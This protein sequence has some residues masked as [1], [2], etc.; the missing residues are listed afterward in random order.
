MGPGTTWQPVFN[1]PAFSTPESRAN[2]Q[3]LC[4][5]S[6]K[7]YYDLVKER[8]SRKL[9]SKIAFIR[10]EELNPFP[11]EFLRTEIAKYGD[12]EY[13]WVQEEC[14]NQGA[15]TFIAPRLQQLIRGQVIFC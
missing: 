12:V 5:L 10:L 14:Q 8:E 1:D 7:L 2:V 9:E 15:Y 3:R 13:Y 11:A 4:F 6:G